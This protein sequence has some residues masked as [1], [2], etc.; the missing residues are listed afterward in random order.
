MLAL[1]R[2]RCSCAWRWRMAR[3]LSV[4]FERLR[5]K[6]KAI[7]YTAPKAAL[8]EL[9]ACKTLEQ[10]KQSLSARIQAAD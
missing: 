8:C 6:S 10:G 4:D 2:K 9:A 7:D 5:S 1:E 3:V